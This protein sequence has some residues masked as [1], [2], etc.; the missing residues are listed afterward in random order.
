MFK[1]AMKFVQQYKCH[2]IPFP[3]I[4]ITRHYTV[5]Q[6]WGA[7]TCSHS[8]WLPLQN[9]YRLQLPIIFLPAPKKPGFQLNRFFCCGSL[10]F[11]GSGFGSPYK[12]PAP[13]T[14]HCFIRI[15]HIRKFINNASTNRI[16]EFS[17]KTLIETGKQFSAI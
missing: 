16:T 15:C 1:M 7:S 11:I 14:A 10:F 8:I 9:V 6:C 2:I 3:Y 13:A 17:M 4:H 12:G 5:H